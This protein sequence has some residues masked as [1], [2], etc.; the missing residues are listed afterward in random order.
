MVVA[1]DEPG[2]TF[3]LGWHCWTRAGAQRLAD[4][5]NASL[6]ADYGD[7]YRDTVWYVARVGDFPRETTTDQRATGREREQG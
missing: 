3:D 7:D 1:D 4:E 6:R 5:R 2:V